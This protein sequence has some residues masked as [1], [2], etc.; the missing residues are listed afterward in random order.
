LVGEYVEVL[1][2]REYTSNI[3]VHRSLFQMNRSTLLWWK[4]LLPLLKMVIEYMS[5]EL[6]KEWFHERY[7]LRNSS[8]INSTSSKALRQGDCMVPK[9]KAHF[10]SCF[11]MLCTL[12]KKLKVNRF[13]L[14]LALEFSFYF[15][16]Q[17][18]W[19]K[20]IMLEC[21]EPHF[22]RN[23]PMKRTRSFGSLGPTTMGDLGKA[24]QIH[25]VVNNHQEEH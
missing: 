4:M 23:Y 1:A 10:W 13:V 12:T 22:Q 3:K 11:N 20:E 6:F 19:T 7:L 21:G 17:D 2:L 18:Y 9:Y 8:S 14:A 15:G 5:W 24:H 16:Y 25:A